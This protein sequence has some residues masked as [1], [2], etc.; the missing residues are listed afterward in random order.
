[1]VGR[2]VS[3][4]HASPGVTRDRL[5]APIEHN[6]RRLYLLDTGGISLDGEELSEKTRDS[7]LEALDEAG[8]V[9]FLVDVLNGVTE[10]DLQ[11]ARILRRQSERVWLLVNKVERKDDEFAFHEFHSLG[12]GDPHPISALHGM[13]IADLWERLEAEYPPVPEPSEGEE[14]MRMALVGRP[15]AGKSSIVN[16][17]LGEDR[18]IVSD[19]P[20]TT[21]DA[22]DSSL[23]WHG[24]DVILVDT[25]GLRRKARV[26]KSLEIYSNLRSLSAIDYSDVVV[27]VLDG[28]RE[29]AEQDLKIASHA[30]ESGRGI[31]LCMNKWDLVDKESSTMGDYVRKI[32]DQLGFVDYAPLIFISAK[33]HQR[34]HLL[35]EK[36][37][38]VFEHRQKRYPTRE[39]NLLLENIMKSKPP[40]HHRG[41]TGKM[42]YVSQ[43]YSAP[44]TFQIFVNN[45]D[46]FPEHYRRFLGNRFR[47]AFQ[48]EGSKVRLRLSPRKAE[49]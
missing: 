9:L 24:R 20:G 21:R 1:M 46:W 17:L 14:S 4:V 37:W 11:V 25:A 40:H 34:I 8:L 13:G 16:A 32:R 15:N 23:R 2:Q 44:P 30:H 48:I 45:A 49:S 12:L 26:K 3:V 7:A 27:L 38:S 10:E 28:D 39:L 31:V 42:Y 29:L 18:M 36:A 5:S 41:G 19:I 6:G 33:T 47:E 35:L 43:V 22:V